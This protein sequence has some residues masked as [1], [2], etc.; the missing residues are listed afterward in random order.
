MRFCFV[1]VVGLPL[2]FRKKKNTGFPTLQSGKIQSSGLSLIHRVKVQKILYFFTVSHGRDRP[3]VQ[4]RFTKLVQKDSRFKKQRD[5]GPSS[6]PWVAKINA[7][8]TS[9]WKHL[10]FPPR[11]PLCR[12]PTCPDKADLRVVLLASKAKWDS[13]QRSFS[14]RERE[15][16]LRTIYVASAEILTLLCTNE[17]RSW[18]ATIADS[19]RCERC[20]AKVPKRE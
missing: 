14:K 13:T 9:H 10:L 19:R 11:I 2:E 7:L 12:C 17:M 6:C 3:A 4:R 8:F 15:K 16:K 5:A 1:Q 20:P 18:H